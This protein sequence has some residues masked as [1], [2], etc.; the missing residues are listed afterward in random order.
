MSKTPRTGLHSERNTGGPR[1]IA[2]GKLVT[3]KVER[4]EALSVTFRDLACL[5]IH[6]FPFNINRAAPEG[7]PYA[8]RP[9]RYAPCRLLC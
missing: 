1:H 4:H 7:K 5:I 6:P 2:Q 8:R 3:R 9:S